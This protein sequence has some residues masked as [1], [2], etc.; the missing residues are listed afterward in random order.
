M[1]PIVISEAQNITVPE[2]LYAI[3]QV[4]K[5]AMVYLILA[6]TQ[7][8]DP[9]NLEHAIADQ[10]G[11]KE[12]AASAFEE[13]YLPVSNLQTGVY[14]FYAVDEAGRM[15]ERSNKAVIL[16]NPILGVHDLD[17]SFHYRV[18][19]G[20]LQILPENGHSYHVTIYD[21]TGRVM[22]QK[23]GLSGSQ[24]FNL[25]PVP[26]IYLLKII[27]QNQMLAIKILSSKI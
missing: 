16:N 8:N 18:I 2:V 24:T 9:G 17:K 11:V 14:Y 23:S 5:P 19:N 21:M 10:K 1:R 7:I 27:S 12:F 13:V 25:P 20:Q 15:S 6:G 26:G 3:A 22:W 4:D